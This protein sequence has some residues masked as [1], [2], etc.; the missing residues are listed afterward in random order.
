MEFVDSNWTILN[1]RLAAH[2]DIPVSR[3]CTSGACPCRK[4]RCVEV[5]DAGQRAQGDRERHEPPRR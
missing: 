4:I 1:D 5:Y 3:A 2:Y